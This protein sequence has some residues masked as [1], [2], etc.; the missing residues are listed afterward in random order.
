MKREGLQVALW[1]ARETCVD[2]RA[3]IAGLPLWLNRQY[4]VRFHFGMAVTDIDFPLSALVGSHGRQA[5][6][7]F[8]VVRISS[9]SFPNSLPP[10]A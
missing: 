3:V 5:A 4:G 7:G 6:S 8:A 2:P 9:H 10:V 1:S